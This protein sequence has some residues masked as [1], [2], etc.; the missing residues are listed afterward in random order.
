MPA[1][2]RRSTAVKADLPTRRTGRTEAF[3]TFVVIS[4]AVLVLGPA[5]KP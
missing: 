3:G 4:K 2:E 1:S 5:T